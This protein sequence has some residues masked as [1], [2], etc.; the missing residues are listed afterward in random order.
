MPS[1]ELT[2]KETLYLVIALKHY[3][4]HLMSN[5]IAE[6]D[7]T[8]GTLHDLLMAQWLLKRLDKTNT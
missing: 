4:Q 6:Q 7:D 1:V 8:H 3:E 5:M 2:D